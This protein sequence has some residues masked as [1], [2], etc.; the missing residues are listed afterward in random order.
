MGMPKQ[1]KPD[2]LQQESPAM[3]IFF[4]LYAMI[5]SWILSGYTLYNIDRFRATANE[6]GIQDEYLNFLYICLAVA[7][8]G[9]T[10][11]GFKA[12][13]FPTTIDVM[14]EKE[15]AGKTQLMKSLKKNGKGDGKQNKKDDSALR[16]KCKVCSTQV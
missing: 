7:T 8:I 16:E 9:V 13:L 2:E 15:Q 5:I 6:K 14:T 12:L 4:R 11:L 3:K 1:A 10:Y